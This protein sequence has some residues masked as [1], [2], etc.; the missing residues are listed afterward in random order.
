MHLKI[1]VKNLTKLLFGS[2]IYIRNCGIKT[3]KETGMK[4]SEKFKNY[5]LPIL[6]WIP[7]GI[8]LGIIG[9]VMGSIFHISLDGVTT[10]REHAPILLY[11]LPLG[12]ALTAFLYGKFAS[13]GNIDIKRVFQSVRENKDIPIVMIPLI[14]IGTLITHM[15]GGSA[16]KEGAALQLGGS[17]GYNLAEKLNVDK[18]NTKF[19]VTAGMS[20]V[21]AALFG[22]PL[23]AIVFSLEVTRKGKFKFFGLIPGFFSSVIAYFVSI[24]MGISPVRFNMP[25]IADYNAY[26]ILKVILLAVLC[27]GVCI[28]FATA[29]HKTKFFLEKYI[30]NSYIRAAV[31]GLIIVLLT[32]FMRTT[33]YNGAGMGIIKEAISGDAKN[34]AFLMKIIFTAITVGAGFKGGEI[35]PTFFI[36]ATFGCFMGQILGVD[37]GVSS[38]LGLVALFSGM[39]KC[40]VTSL[41]LAAEVFGGSE[42]PLFFIVIVIAFILSGSFGLYENK[43][44]K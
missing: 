38:A 22:T 15:L 36:G 17:M 7:I 1:I 20:S 27:A 37:A 3:F 43:K 5:I 8:L 24:F 6:K 10:L 21:F 26:I 25:K 11:F 23:A 14:F 30:P 4:S 9:G 33:D 44:L 29:I 41:L 16:G 31:G 12:G 40:P 2:I 39:T 19:M 13:K 34:S 35:V 32:I 28:L 18:K 42:I